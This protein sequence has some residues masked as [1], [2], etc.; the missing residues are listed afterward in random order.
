MSLL[1]LEFWHFLFLSRFFSYTTALHQAVKN[2]LPEPVVNALLDAG[3]DTKATTWDHC[4]YS[5]FGH[6]KLN[7]AQ[8]DVHHR[9]DRLHA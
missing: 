4:H 2:E 9:Y 5:R 7:A 8:L 3:A 1:N 6:V